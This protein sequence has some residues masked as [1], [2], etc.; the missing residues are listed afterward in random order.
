MTQRLDYSTI[1]PAGVKAFED[2]HGYNAL[3]SARLQQP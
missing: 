1:A 2:V 3:A